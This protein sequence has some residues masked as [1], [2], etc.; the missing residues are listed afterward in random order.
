LRFFPIEA[1]S[2]L[3]SIAK[4]DGKTTM[5]ATELRRNMTKLWIVAALLFIGVAGIA[6][7]KVL[8]LLDPVV[9]RIAA[10]DPECDLRAGP[11]T[12]RLPDGNRITF[13]IKPESIPVVKPLQFEVQVEGFD[14]DSVEV[15]FQGIGMNMGFNRPKLVAQGEGK[16]SG[17]GM[18]P[19]CVRDAMEWEAKVLVYTDEGIVAAPFRF[20]TVKPGVELPQK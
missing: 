3:K 11:C 18:I 8:P 1:F 5:P 15:D 13:G 17:N 20:I 7:Y 12:G 4:P 19:V 9:V 16:Y 10:L 6:A 2:G 14:S